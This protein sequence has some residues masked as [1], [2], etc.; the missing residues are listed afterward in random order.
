MNVKT[1]KSEKS[2][3][4]SIHPSGHVAFKRA[5]TDTNQRQR[6]CMRMCLLELGNAQKRKLICQDAVKTKEIPLLMR[7]CLWHG[8]PIRPWPNRHLAPV[9]FGN[10][11]PPSCPRY[12][13][14][15]ASIATTQ[16]FVRTSPS[17]SLRGH[18]SRLPHLLLARRPHHTGRQPATLPLR[19]VPRTDPMH[20]SLCSLSRSDAGTPSP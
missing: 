7:V 4:G 9:Q 14:P 17:R 15:L 1:S 11:L 18:L 12:L 2:G 19:N 8:S 6:S 16:C 10:K 3:Y 5:G 13:R 20:P